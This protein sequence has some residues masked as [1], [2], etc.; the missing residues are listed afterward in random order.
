[1]RVLTATLLGSALLAVPPIVLE[2]QR[3][4]APVAPATEDEYKQLAGVNEVL[5][6][7]AGSGARSL[8][9]VIE[10]QQLEFDPTKTASNP[11]PNYSQRNYSSSSRNSSI[12]SQLSLQQQMQ[13]L[14]QQ[15][16]QIMQATDPR[17]REQRMRSWMQSMQKLQ[18][19]VMRQ[20][21]QQA[22]Q[23]QR[24]LLQQQQKQLAQQKQKTGNLG[25][26]KIVTTSRMFELNLRDEVVVRR[27]NLPF[28]YD[29]KGNVKEYTPEEIQKL[30]GDNPKLPGYAAKL[31]DLENGQMVRVYI[32]APEN[33][34][35]GGV[36]L[37][38][39]IIRPEVRA[40]VIYG[41]YDTLMAK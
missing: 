34:E 36:D 5:G 24:N 26:Y 27:M 41:D 31:E 40:V 6:K 8:S 15:R 29:D 13:R 22:S 18:M 28:A 38:G 32:A 23:L 9:L 33:G 37:V 16:A 12:R 1:M 4:P 19:Q 35:I 2:A 25:P 3:K 17:Q 10:S 21:A 30:R 20:Q 39:N 7:L 14:M 11:R